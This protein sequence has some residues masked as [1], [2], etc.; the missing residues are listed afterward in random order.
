[1]AKA[2]AFDCITNGSDARGSLLANLDRILSMAQSAQKLRESGQTTMFDLF[3]AEVATPLTGIDLEASA[4]AAT[5]DARL[6]E[7]AA[8]R[9]A[10]RQPV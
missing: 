6:G 7:G 3:G 5:G 8:R 1:M 9:L 2:G 4:R 10:L